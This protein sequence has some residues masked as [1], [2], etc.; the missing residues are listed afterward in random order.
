MK[1]IEQAILESVVKAIGPAKELVLLHR[2]YFPPTAWEY[3]KEC[4]DTGWVSSAG[5]YVTKFEHMLAATTGCKRAVA[6]VNGTAALEICFRLV[7]VQAGDEVL[8][9]S[10]S[11]VATANAI[12]HCGATPHFIDVSID[13]LSI[14]PDVL[15]SRLQQIAMPSDHGVINRE[16]GKRIAAL[17]LMH[18]FGHPGDLDAIQGICDEYGIPLVEDAAE[19]LGSFYKERHTGRFGR[20]AAVSFNG[21]KILTTGGGG[22]ILT[23]DD[24]LADRAKHLTTT[25][26]VPHAWEFHHDE[27]AWNFR[28]PNLNAALGVAQ[29]EILPELIQAKRTLA[30]RYRN[31]F[32]ETP[33][34]RFL[35]EPTDSTSN[36]WLNGIMLENSDSFSLSLT[37][38]LLNE[39]GYQ[40]RP[41]W[42]PMHLLPMYRSCSRSTMKT[43]E[44]LC[45]R[46]INIPSSADLVLAPHATS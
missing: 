16:T 30:Q 36:Y 18:C 13:R 34:V 37:L 46:F 11:F 33:D 19:S 4:L 2:P 25:A 43:T 10:L 44:W 40:S 1:S 41:I 14:C 20:I 28:L 24:V 12:S 42:E 26:K 32:E 45:E 7:G 9:P 6:T 15:K 39:S 22:A 3:V 29:L 31:A 38:K 35:L 23:D 8:C 27:I 21:N 5:S 17:C